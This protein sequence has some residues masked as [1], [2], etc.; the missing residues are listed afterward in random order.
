MDE[1]EN[2]EATKTEMLMA[3]ARRRV[4]RS[5]R[6]TKDGAQAKV[7]NLVIRGADTRSLPT[8]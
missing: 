3:L 8:G 1:R 6:V 7:R 2:K 5:Q 4:K